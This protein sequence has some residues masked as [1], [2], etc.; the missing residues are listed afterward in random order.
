M[1]LPT[2]LFGALHHARESLCIAQTHAEWPGHRARLQEALNIVDEV[3]AFSC[4]QWSK[5]DMPSTELDS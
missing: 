2:D 4:P 1:P 5:Y 3:G